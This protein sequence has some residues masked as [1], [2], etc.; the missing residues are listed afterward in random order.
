MKQIQTVDATNGKQTNTSLLSALV[1]GGHKPKGVRLTGL[2][3][4]LL[5]TGNVDVATL[6]D[7]KDVG[8]RL[9]SD[10]LAIVGQNRLYWP[11]LTSTATCPSKTHA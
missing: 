3:L 7:G 9:L 4:V 2:T 8:D 5:N 1:V 10:C 11:H 6:K